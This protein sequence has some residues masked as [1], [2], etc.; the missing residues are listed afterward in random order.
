MLTSWHHVFTDAEYAPPG[1]PHW[2]EDVLHLTV[3][4]L[5]K[6][7]WSACEPLAD[8]LEEA[9][10]CCWPVLRG[11]RRRDMMPVCFLGVCHREFMER[12]AEAAS[13]ERTDRPPAPGPVSSLPCSPAVAGVSSP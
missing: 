4:L 11:L 6:R 13:R 2:T 8:A 12:R 7:T 5:L 3:A 10:Y 9:G 1:D